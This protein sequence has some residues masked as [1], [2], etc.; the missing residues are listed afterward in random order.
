MKKLTVFLISI[1]I[2]FSFV[3]VA[4]AGYRNC[5]RCSCYKYED[6]GDLICYCGH[7][8]GLHN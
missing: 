2:L 1:L 7:G 5:Q 3:S 4:F 6:R 8:Y